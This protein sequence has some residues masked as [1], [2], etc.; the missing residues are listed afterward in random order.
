MRPSLFSP[1]WYRVSEQQPRLRPEVCIRRQ[2]V[3]GDRW[4]LVV[5]AAS[6]RNLRVNRSAYQFIARCDGERSVRQIW[7]EL[8]EQL[9]DAAPSQD[10]VIRTLNQLED[11][12][13]ISSGAASSTE[14]LVRRRNERRKQRL[15][16]FVNPFALRIPLGDPSAWL[17]RLTWLSHMMFNPV[18]FWLWVTGTAAAAVTA[19]SEWQALS[20]TAAQT[21][22]NTRYLLLAWFCFP[23]IKALH[24]L[25]HA[26]AVRRWGG[27]VPEIGC[28]LFLLVPAPYVDA[29]SAAAFHARYQRVI[30]GAAGIMVELMLAAIGLALWLNIQPGLIHDVAFVTM[31]IACVSTLIFNANPLLPFDGYHILCDALHLPN[32]AARSK[33]WWAAAVQRALGGPPISAQMP[34][35]LGERK[36]LVL[37]APLAL[38]CRLAIAGLIVL[39]LGTQ[40]SVLGA[41]A[42]LLLVFVLVARPLQRTLYGAI[43]TVPAGSARLRAKGLVTAAGAA[44]LAAVC[45]VPLPFHTVAS[46]VVWPSEQARVR[47]DVDGFI[48][49]VLVRDGERVS[50]GQL[51]VARSDPALVAERARL[52]SRLEQ[53]QTTRFSTSFAGSEQIRNAEE[54]ISRV[55]SDLMRTEEKI[56]RLDVR[57]RTQGTLVLPKQQDLHATFLRQGETIGYV[58]EASRLEV[59]A[60]VPEYEATLVRDHTRYV[61]VR[62]ADDGDPAPAQVVRDSLA[63]TFDLPSSALGDLGG[64]PHALDP[65]DTSGLRAR[66][67]VVLIDLHVPS[68][69]LQRI[70]GRVWVRF[71]HP[72]EP[73]AKRWYRWTRQLFLQHFDPTN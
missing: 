19:A 2:Q 21:A 36:W 20:A 8:C 31:L 56:E 29:S 10:D 46:A 32:L 41:A 71:D 68:K 5:S 45:F 13:L 66:Q 25:G 30:V 17:A 58:L 69:S 67:P 26:L 65:S 24:E 7:D 49:D 70:G 33:A 34:L 57:A 18:T 43:H 48:T 38:I 51:L 61:E 28:T 39:W 12:D 11:H 44:V 6:G 1:G 40:S 64:G 14:T 37:Y 47:A 62:F 52:A 23:V 50:A 53:L 60:A 15:K 35:S 27:E 59:R 63:T 54:E 4:Y 55:Q 42:A 16:G 3:R 73:A 72:P 22:S 9:Q